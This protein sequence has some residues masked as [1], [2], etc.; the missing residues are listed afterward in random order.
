MWTVLLAAHV[1]TD[2][3]LDPS[4]KHWSSYKWS[5][6]AWNWSKLWQS[7]KPCLSAASPWPNLALSW[8]PYTMPGDTISLQ[9]HWRHLPAPGPS[10]DPVTSAEQL[11]QPDKC[12]IFHHYAPYC[13]VSTKSVSPE[14]VGT[15]GSEVL[16]TP[17]CA[18]R[19]PQLRAGFKKKNGKL[20]TFCG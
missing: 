18:G 7:S 20:S 5:F 12:F 2:K 6:T 3:V 4:T 9:L 11:C 19:F 10:P 14:K 1:S 17:P 8:L 13:D 15:V 16:P